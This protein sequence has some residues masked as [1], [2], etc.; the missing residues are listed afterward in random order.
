MAILDMTGK[1]CPIPVI[2]AKKALRGAS[3]GQRV[4]LLVDND[5]ARQN[6]E[7]MATGQPH[8]VGGHAFTYEAQEDGNI[9]VT[10]TAAER[11]ASAE[12]TGGLV[13]AIGCEWMGNAS[14]GVGS[15]ELGRILMKSFL[16]S[17]T[18]LDVPPEHLLFYNSGIYLTTQGANT[19]EDLRTL[20][21]KGTVIHS[22]GTCLDYYQLKEKLAIGSITNMYAIAAAMAE[23]DRLINL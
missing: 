21:Q 5:V 23:A 3:P 4:Q 12:D 8:T 16:Y 14:S 19:L 22:C 17:L 15:D 7:K 10:I 9:L 1:P 20:E 11:Q 2:E 18:E 13:V 6:L